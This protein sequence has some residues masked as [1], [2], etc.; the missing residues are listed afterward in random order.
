MATVSQNYANH[1]R[2][3]PPFH[4]FLMPVAAITFG[5]AV[6]N[7]VRNF[8]FFSVWLVVLAIAWILHLLLTRMYAVKAQ[9][10]VIRLEE[11]LRLSTLLPEPLRLRIPELT[12]SQLIALRFASDSEVPVLVEKALAANSPAVEIKKSIVNW[13]PD[14][15]RI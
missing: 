2:R 15:F 6:Y 14:Y 3:D 4:F 11:R 8:N 7:A 13:R 1:I 5:V 9:D 10:R 12:V